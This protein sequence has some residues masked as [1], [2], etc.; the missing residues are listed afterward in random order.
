MTGVGNVSSSSGMFNINGV[1]MDLE[2]AI[3]ALQ[4]ARTEAIDQQIKDQMDDMQNKNAKLAQLNELM[5]QVRLYRDDGKNYQYISDTTPELTIDGETKT[6]G[7]W[8][9]ELGLTWTDVKDDTRGANW[10]TNNNAITAA[11][12]S[13]QAKSPP[14]QDKIDKLTALRDIAGA[15]SSRSQDPNEYCYADN[16]PDVTIGGET[17]TMAE[18]FKE[19]G[20]AWKDVS[21]SGDSAKE[22]RGICW[23]ANLSNIKGV[24][25]TLNNNSQLDM[26]RL[27]GL[28]NK[29][30]Q[31]FELMSNTIAKL[32]KA[33]ET[34]V[35]NMR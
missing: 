10:S 31:S 25:D 15:I 23:D 22:Q 16:T 14:D 13:E 33:R 9:K 4:M 6:L 26:I 8:F 32:N 28:M 34:I 12:K 24:M 29:R 21:G 17:R 11:I 30:N 18:W 3:M 35:S 2:T 20:I 27:Q 19:Y 5:S 1:E 7:K